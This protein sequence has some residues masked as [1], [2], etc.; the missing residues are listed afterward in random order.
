MPSHSQFRPFAIVAVPLALLLGAVAGC[1]QSDHKIAPVSGRVT[2]NQKPVAGVHVSFQP[3]A[4]GASGARAGFGSVGIT[5]DQGRF[6]L[7]TID[8]DRLGAVVGRHVVRL[9]AKELRESGS[10]EAAPAM[11]NPLPPQSL[12][13]SLTFEVPAEGTDKANFD[14]KF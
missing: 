1:G 14:L 2:L 6:Q 8:S 12:D 3:S 13:G 4:G 11:K 9:T 5:D 10:S 7:K